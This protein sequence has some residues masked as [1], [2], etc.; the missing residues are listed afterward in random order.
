[1]ILFILECV[2]LRVVSQ[3]WSDLGV[4]FCGE[5][6]LIFSVQ[7]TEIYRVYLGTGTGTGWRTNFGIHLAC[8]IVKGLPIVPKYDEERIS[9]E[10]SHHSIGE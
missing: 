1:M 5:L 8:D 10:E 3:R 7:I 6:V 9:R 2:C 4:R